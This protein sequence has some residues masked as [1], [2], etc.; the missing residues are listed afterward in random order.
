MNKTSS[1]IYQ[2]LALPP[3]KKLPQNLTPKNPLD[4]FSAG[5]IGYIMFYYFYLWRN[6]THAVA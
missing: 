5:N 2:G 3:L 4:I 6:L 1:L